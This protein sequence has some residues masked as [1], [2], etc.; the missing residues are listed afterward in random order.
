MEGSD[1]IGGGVCGFD[2]ADG[3]AAVGGYEFGRFGEDDEGRGK[4]SDG[5]DA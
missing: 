1:E 5:A 4:G 2:I 3:V